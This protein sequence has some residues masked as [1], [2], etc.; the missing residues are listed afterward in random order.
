VHQ[1][2]LACTDRLSCGTERRVILNSTSG[3]HEVLVATDSQA[4]N[5]LVEQGNDNASPEL[6]RLQAESRVLAI[7]KGTKGTVVNWYELRERQLGA[8]TSEPFTIA[9][10]RANGIKQVLGIRLTEGR[11][12]G[13]LVLAL[14]TEVQYEFAWP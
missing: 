11:E 4:L 9:E 5:V 6:R 12:A 13:K 2:D 1:F 8:P 3:S 7:P 14:S 10:Q